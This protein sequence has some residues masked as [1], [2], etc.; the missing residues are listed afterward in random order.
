[1]KV[2]KVSITASL[3]STITVQTCT[4]TGKVV[5]TER[6]LQYGVN[7][8]PALTVK[9]VTHKSLV[10]TLALLLRSKDVTYLKPY[11][12]LCKRNT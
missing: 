9:R 3:C 2:I 10:G 1:M 12:I 5:K 8:G 6:H 11:L 7:I 4:V